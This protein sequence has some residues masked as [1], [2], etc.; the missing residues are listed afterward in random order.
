[1]Q[2]PQKWNTTTAEMST[3]EFWV[4]KE[5]IYKLKYD[6]CLFD[7]VQVLE[8]GFYQQRLTSPQFVTLLILLSYSVVVVFLW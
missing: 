3:S 1:M 5:Q 7:V 8:S 2:K 4:W 6:A